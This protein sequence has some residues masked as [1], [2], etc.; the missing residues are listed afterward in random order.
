[1]SCGE[2]PGAV[3]SGDETTVTGIRANHPLRIAVLVKQVPAGEALSLGSDGRLERSDVRLEMNAFCRR[4]VAKGVELARAS[5]GDVTVFTL[6]PPSAEDVLREAVAWGADRG[7]HLCD[8]E[9]AG[10]DTLAT[11]RALAA[12]L[13]ARGSFDLVLLGRNTTDGETGQVGP[14]VAQ[15]L[16]LAF[17]GGV[18]ELELNGE[19]L[20]LD[21]EHDEGRE[22]VRLELPAV[23]SVAERLCAPCKASVEDRRA[24]AANRVCR[25]AARDVGAGPWGEAGSA[26]HVGEVR[27]VHRQ[28]K[29]AV[30]D[31]E[32][33][34]QVDAAV[35]C[36]DERGALQW[37]RDIEE[38]RG[39]RRS[40]GVDA[41]VG[42]RSN[43][44]RVD[45]APGGGRLGGS[46][47]LIGALL[48]DPAAGSNAGL[49]GEAARLA[50]EV[51]GEVVALCAPAR[52]R[53]F[54]ATNAQQRTGQ[55]RE[56]PDKTLCAR[57]FGEMGADRV[58]RLVAAAGSSTDTLSTDDV[59][60]GV[61]RWATTARPWAIV[62]PSTAFGREVAGR[63]AAALDAG[64]VGDAIGLRVADGELVAAKPAFSGALVAD[65]TWASELR[66]VTIRPG[67]LPASRRRSHLARTADLR[68]EP[69][70]RV[71]T[72]SFTRDDEV[73]ALA[74]ARVVV[75]VGM[76]VDPDEY[77]LLTPLV[78]LLG[79][80]LAGT[81]KVTDRAWMPRSRQVG[82]TGRSISPRLYVAVGLSGEFN[83]MVGVRGADTILAI[84]VDRDAP[85]FRETDVGIVGDWREVLPA[86]LAQLR[87][88]ELAA[89]RRGS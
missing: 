20:R 71:Q 54:A 67:V 14:Q 32:V 5:G 73:E 15:L 33:S 81:R 16:D 43:A 57:D 80:E 60:H 68:V 86:L 23:L 17:A 26:T 79:G 25:L 19:V 13:R 21:L 4:A 58:V 18:R 77:R 85:V 45:D 36:L 31:G 59:A 82:V 27:V 74:R 2:A 30:L 38:R 39:A 52:A 76:G 62:A 47:R 22:S 34:T 9:F 89:S 64:L 35:R 65:I 28:R 41:P 11:S 49:V 1:M 83:H 24:V 72:L 48:E 40:S 3:V 42:K 78:E 50:A 7:I 61:C 70:G 51:G 56:G 6:G 10:S 37:T 46:A 8:G 55:G 75:G 53:S 87:K 44:E 84:N 29:G 63:V 12:G 88:R 69:R 66:M